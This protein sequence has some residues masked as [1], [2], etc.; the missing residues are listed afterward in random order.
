[1]L[2]SEQF[3]DNKFVLYSTPN[4][5]KEAEILNKTKSLI[6]SYEKQLKNLRR[7]GQ[8]SRTN[9]RKVRD[10]QEKLENAQQKSAVASLLSMINNDVNKLE[11]ALDAVEREKVDAI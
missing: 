6:S 1:T 10:I 7:T 2:N 4:N 9:L 8:V 3:K 5:P 11:A